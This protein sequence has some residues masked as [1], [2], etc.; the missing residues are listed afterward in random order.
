MAGP[1]QGGFKDEQ[2]R[3]DPGHHRQRALHRGERRHPWRGGR[4]STTAS[5]SLRR[6]TMTSTAWASEKLAEGP[7]HGP[8]RLRP[9]PASKRAG[10]RW[11]GGRRHL[12]QHRPAVRAQCVRT[13]SLS[14]GHRAPMGGFQGSQPVDGRPLC[15]RPGP[16]AR[17]D[18][19]QSVPTR[20]DRGRD[21]RRGEERVD[22]RRRA[23]TGRAARQHLPPVQFR[24]IGRPVWA[25]RS[26]GGRSDHNPRGKRAD[27]TDPAPARPPSSLSRSDGGRDG[28]S[29]SS[30]SAASLIATATSRWCSPSRGWDGSRPIFPRSGWVRE[31]GAAHPR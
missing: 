28:P 6:C 1:S 19:D 14:P 9:G 29:P 12:P 20:G 3:V 27:I 31:A 10:D 22:D 7:P 2:W 4:S 25:R 18:A 11:R 13:G 15:Q 23:G 24:S 8:E 26:R 5:T 21:P 16:A 17:A 30:C